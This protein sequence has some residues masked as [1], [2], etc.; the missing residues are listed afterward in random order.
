MLWK[1]KFLSNRQVEIFFIMKKYFLLFAF[2]FLFCSF[3][4]NSN[5]NSLLILDNDN[6]TLVFVGDIMGHSPQFEAAYN[7]QTNSYNYDICFQHVKSYISNADFA[8]ANLEV[9]LA[10]MPYSGYPNF[11]SPDALLDALKN[12]GFRIL[13]TANNHVLD[14]G[15]FGMER[16]IRQIEKRNLLHMGSYVDAIQRDTLYPLIV[17]SKGVKI[18]FLNCTYGTNTHEVSEPNRVNYIDTLE[19]INDI[20]RANNLNADF[21]IMTIHWGTEYELQANEAQRKIAQF[22]VNHGI[23]LIIGSHP[24]VVQNAEIFYDKDSIPVPVFYSLGNF[25][26]NQ[27]KLNTNGGILVKVEIDAK[28]KTFKNSS[29]LPVYVHRGILNGEYQ[30]HLIPTSDFIQKPSNYKILTSDSISLTVFDKETRSRLKNIN[31]IQN[32]Q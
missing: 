4:Q 1:N 30:Y 15:K 22:L 10:G 28:S 23:N 16:T 25:I 19:I 27:R 12:A 20:K 13:Q 17:E 24:H 9:P 26:S 8:L 11:S 7:S 6:V 21:R 31:L 29:F 14:R 18:A 2:S 5:L 32:N 3:L